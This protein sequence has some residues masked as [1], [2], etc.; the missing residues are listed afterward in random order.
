[1]SDSDNTPGYL[2]ELT[3][4]ELPYFKTVQQLSREVAALGT[5]T[6]ARKGYMQ[7][8]YLSISSSVI[9]TIFHEL[10][11]MSQTL[12]T[13]CK[14]VKRDGYAYA[15]S[16]AIERQLAELVG[17][18]T[19]AKKSAKLKMWAIRLARNAMTG[20]D[21]LIE[22]LESGGAYCEEIEQSFCHEV[23]ELKPADL[24]A[25]IRAFGLQS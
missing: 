13:L 17:F 23:W 7:A 2:D 21:L 5:S 19:Y 24:A 1:M 9:E 18:L 12:V 4:G 8:Y 10:E 16:P 22:A 3:G 15:R 25:D 20:F 14:A 6:P 11:T